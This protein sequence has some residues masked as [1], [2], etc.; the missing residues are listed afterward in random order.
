MR[1]GIFRTV[2]TSIALTIYLFRAQIARNVFHRANTVHEHNQ[3]NRL[4]DLISSTKSIIPHMIMWYFN[5]TNGVW[6]GSA[7]VC[8]RCAFV[9]EWRFK[10]APASGLFRARNVLLYECESNVVRK[11]CF[12]KI[13]VNE[14]RTH[15]PHILDM[16]RDDAH[17]VETNE[18]RLLFCLKIEWNSA[19]LLICWIEIKQESILNSHDTAISSSQC[20]YISS[21]CNS[22]K[23]L[24]F[25]ILAFFAFHQ[26][27]NAHNCECKNVI[28]QLKHW[29]QKPTTHS[30]RNDTR[31]ASQIQNNEFRISS[32]RKKR[33]SH[34]L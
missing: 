10:L 26:H 9:C 32:R 33:I 30:N 5:K 16:P 21:F 11:F 15:F 1:C 28:G 17:R 22:K 3:L 34:S 23:E 31:H 6:V 27:M 12:C 7:V 4:V 13:N 8:V 29:P 14:T 2:T 18:L 24:A 25:G 19:N 20:R